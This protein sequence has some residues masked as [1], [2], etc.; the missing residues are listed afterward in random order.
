LL[1]H[2]GKIAAT[3]DVLAKLHQE[4]IALPKDDPGYGL[5]HGWNESDSCLFPDP[6]VWWRPY[7]ANS[8]WAARG[9][10]ALAEIWPTLRPGE[11]SRAHDWAI[12]AGVLRSRLASSV[13]ASVRR[14]LSPAYVP[15]LPGV[16]LTFRESLAQEMPSP[17]QWP[18]RAYS[19][20]LQADVLPPDLTDLVIDTMRGHG[21]M[22]LGVVA[23]VGP[24]SAEGRDILGFISYGY[25]RALLRQDRI[26][27]YILFLY[28]HRFHAHTAGSWTAGEVCDITG[29]LP[30][31]CMPAQMTI[32]LLV[33]WMLAFEEDDADR[34]HL[35]RALPRT[36]LAS[37]QPITIADAPTRWGK[38]DLTLQA[39]PAARRVSARVVVGGPGR[40]GETLLRLRAP[41]NW[42]LAAARVNGTPHPLSGSVTDTLILDSR[43][44]RIFD[45]EVAYSAG[46]TT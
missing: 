1:R 25:A 7:F 17:Q 42:G 45:V 31:F 32:P 3:A 28:S 4:S 21:A 27:E 16:H 26:P 18:H 41:K 36:W 8:A 20:L 37:G 38:I 14:D 46:P 9:W 34:L 33:R 5:V 24:V 10:R 2:A 43:R 6:S 44:E 29:G 12:R 19:E 40:P 30:L 23:N 39:D 35:A 15:P 13:R 22:S 11:T